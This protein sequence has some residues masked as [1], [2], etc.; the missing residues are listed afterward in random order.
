LSSA[1][2]PKPP[3][4]DFE[5]GAGRRVEPASHRYRCTR[6]TT[7]FMASVNDL[8]GLVFKFQV[9]NV[10]RSDGVEGGTHGFGSGSVGASEFAT[11][12]PQCAQHSCAVEPLSLT[13]LAKAHRPTLRFLS[14]WTI[15]PIIS[16]AARDAMLRR[17]GG[18]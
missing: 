17:S 18:T 8:V 14:R 1:V 3:D 13:V 7:A 16:G 5:A 11:Q 12:L 6:A 4:P 9:R 2:G 10:H 15:E